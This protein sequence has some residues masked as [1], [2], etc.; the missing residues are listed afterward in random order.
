MK[1]HKRENI[2]IDRRYVIHN[3]DAAIAD[4]YDALVELI[5]NCD[6]SYRRL[7]KRDRHAPVGH[8]LIETEHRRN[9]P[10]LLI[11]RDKAE[12]MTINAM[13]EKLKRM[14][15]RTSEISDRGFM[16]RGFKDCTA[17]GDIRVD[18]IVNGRHYACRLTRD[19]D[20]DLLTPDKGE[21][22]TDALR[23]N[24]GIR[25]NGTVVTLECSE[26]VA[27]PRIETLKKDLP[28]HY[29]LRD[30][31]AGNSASKI[32]IR[33]REGAKPVEFRAPKNAERV[34]AQNFTLDEYPE[35]DCMI[36]IWKSP[37]VLADKDQRMRKS[38]ILIKDGRTIHECS[39]FGVE[40]EPLARH[41]YGH[42]ECAHIVRL[43]EEHDERVS[44]KKPHP[45]NNRFLP[46]D[47]MRR[48]LNKR[49]PFANALL[50]K[51]DEVLKGLVEKDRRESEVGRKD[52][53]SAKTARYLSRLAQLAARFLK[54][55]IDSPELGAGEEK[56]VDAALEA[57]ISILPP[58]LKIAVGEERTLCVYVRKTL[59][60][61]KTKVRVQ[62]NDET[63]LALSQTLA[64]RILKSHPKKD[65]VVY[66]SFKVRGVAPGM[67]D[68]VIRHGNNLRIKAAVEVS[69]NREKNEHG[70]ASP[71][72][73]E[74]AKYE[75]AEG[76]SKILKLFAR[77]PELI[78]ESTT[79]YVDSDNPDCAP[80]MRGGRCVLSPVPESNYAEGEI[81]IKGRSLTDNPAVI[82]ARMGDIHAQTKISVKERRIVGGGLRIEFAQ[83]SLGHLRARWKDP[84]V[85]D[86][87]VIL[88]SSDHPSIKPYLG[89]SQNV[90]EQD[91]AQ[92]RVLLAELVSEV[93]CAG[94]LNQEMRKNPGGWEQ[95]G[96]PHEAF[97]S[98][99][100]H[101][102]A[103]ISDFST[104]VHKNFADSFRE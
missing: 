70:F 18:S 34:V 83:E 7:R 22:A 3:R 8:I 60:D 41:Y 20:F 66:D 26:N 48:G 52:V 68:I 84:A 24:L 10:S 61:S 28:L 33:E 57:G 58:A 73:F 98:W 44:A 53:A 27:L 16:A 94:I 43:I 11:V 25:K 47:P 99:N 75:V 92:F 87:S 91:T 39:L 13:R 80:V 49:H 77:F 71:L 82:T 100:Y 2:E 101:L 102:Q 65:E 15:K 51:V 45:R 50:A 9:N 5:T 23:D 67:T 46:I 37:T 59:Y 6:D 4:I 64:N 40:Q 19:L 29:A 72:E 63:I 85:V 90:E 81:E 14:G 89:S 88:I 93:L 76:K 1:V 96:T 95:S 38:G 86:M 56:A 32:Y 103:K 21:N 55:N 78:R 17:L 30:I 35:A 69:L 31:V 97:A 36:E 42:V 54:E 12:G 62:S 74:R 104:L 79:V